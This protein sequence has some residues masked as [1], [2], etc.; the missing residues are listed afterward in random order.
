LEGVKGMEV[1]RGVKGGKEDWIVIMYQDK[2]VVYDQMMD[3]RVME[4]RG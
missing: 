3:R 1:M 4:K 2:V